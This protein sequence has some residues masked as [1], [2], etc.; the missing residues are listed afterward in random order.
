M[1]K[2]LALLL[3]ITFS[4]CAGYQVV[5]SHDL[6]RQE[7]FEVPGQSRDAIFEK[8]KGWIAKS[9]NSARSVIEYENKAEGK[10]IGKGTIFGS[11]NGGLSPVTASFT[12]EED[13][14]DGRVRITVADI[15]MADGRPFY[16]VYRPAVLPQIYQI[17]GDLKAYLLRSGSSDW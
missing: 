1:L 6:G 16:E 7:V 12:L 5:P 8:S 17:P 2:V 10:L 14:K 11:I 9:F 3:A 15:K 4:G 13:I